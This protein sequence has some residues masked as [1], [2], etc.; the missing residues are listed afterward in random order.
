MA[1]LSKNSQYPARNVSI[2]QR[3]KKGVKEHC[4]GDIL[5]ELPNRLSFCNFFIAKV[6]F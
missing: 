1:P 2:L 3:G 5:A 4:E 6:D